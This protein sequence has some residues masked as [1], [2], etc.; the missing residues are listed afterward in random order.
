MVWF[1]L[2]TIVL[3]RVFRAISDAS[4]PSNELKVMLRLNEKE[5]RSD[6]F[7]HTIYAL[8]FLTFDEIVFVVMP[9]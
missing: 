5:L 3:F 4:E 2:L 6:P 9:R 1:P 7:N 8:E